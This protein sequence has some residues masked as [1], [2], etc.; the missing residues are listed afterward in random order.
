MAERIEI[1][2][3]AANSLSFLGD[4]LDSG[5]HTTVINALAD[6]PEERLRSLLAAAL[7]LASNKRIN[8]EESDVQ[9]RDLR[10]NLSK[11]LTNEADRLIRD[12][13]DAKTEGKIEDSIK[14]GEQ[15]RGIRRAVVV[16][17]ESTHLA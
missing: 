2:R 12:A 14:W 8:P 4:K 7:V 6:T 13:G 17:R 11:K 9:R 16:I 1:T 5:D 10:E 3:T 15:A